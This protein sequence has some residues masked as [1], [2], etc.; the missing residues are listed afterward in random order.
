[1]S[2]PEAPHDDPTQVEQPV[3]TDQP[4]TTPPDT[5]PPDTTQITEPTEQLGTRDSTDS[6]DATR[7]FAFVEPGHGDQIADDTAWPP[8][9]PERPS[10]PHAPAIVLG[11]V[12]LAVAVIVLAQELG[13]LSVDWGN[14]GPLGIVTAGAL[15]VLFGLAGLLGSRRK[16]S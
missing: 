4:D 1:M 5:T 6:T 14:I 12:C 10:G 11:L 7:A 16:S 3:Q 13:R 15:L 9:V 2:T 8:A